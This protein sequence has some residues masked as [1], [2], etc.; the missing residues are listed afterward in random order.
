MDIAISIVLIILCIVMAW[1][2]CLYKRQLKKLRREW[3]EYHNNMVGEL[4]AKLTQIE[5]QNGQ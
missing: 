3:L 1:F 5:L 2:T 4:D